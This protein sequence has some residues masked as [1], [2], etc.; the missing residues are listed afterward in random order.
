MSFSRVNIVQ[1][2][3]LPDAF[4]SRVLPTTN[5]LSTPR[6]LT[7]INLAGC[8][9]LTHESFQAIATNCPALTELNIEECFVTDES[10]QA[11]AASCPSLTEL[12]INGS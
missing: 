4:V 7:S 3:R 8:V 11:I 12:T 6:V 10:F 5:D 9:S 2:A 1:R